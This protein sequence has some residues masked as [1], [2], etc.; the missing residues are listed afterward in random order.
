MIKRNS[1]ICWNVFSSLKL[2]V[3]SP[4]RVMAETVRKRESAKLT[5]TVV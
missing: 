1:K 2:T 4:A 3:F 5:R